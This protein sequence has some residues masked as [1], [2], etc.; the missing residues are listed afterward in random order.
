MKI[1]PSTITAAIA[2]IAI[3]ATPLLLADPRGGPR[4]GHELQLHG[5]LG[6][7]GD[8]LDLSE[9]QRDEIKAILIDLREENAAYR[10]QLRGGREA[11]LTTLIQNPNDLLAAQ[12]L[13]DQQTEAENAMRANALKATADALKILTPEQRSKLGT[14]IE[15]RRPR[16]G[17]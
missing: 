5:I 15:Q 13:L 10:D 9:Q 14:L 3:L 1:R 11:I 4:G 16:R 6:R 8:E 17:D 7:L 12:T 2:L